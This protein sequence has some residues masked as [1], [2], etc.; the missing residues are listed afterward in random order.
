MSINNITLPDV[1]LANL[2]PDSLVGT[3][4]AVADSKP[5]ATMVQVEQE[6][7]PVLPRENL[8]SLGH[9][10]KQISIVVNSD[11]AVFLPDAS[12]QFLTGILNACKLS[13]ADVAL[14]NLATET[15]INYKEVV[16]AFQP[17][18]VLLFDVE[19]AAFG[20]P[21]TFPHYQL[22]PFSG[23]TFLYSP[24]LPALEN[25]RAEKMKLW[26]SLKRLF[27]I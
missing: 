23:I 4:K 10:Q 12:L 27:N 6:V 15:S 24:S 1:L 22:Q 20:L 17:K 5:A 16:T 14:V 18:I 26:A 19:P 8:K 2:Y 21:M 25:D 13:M 9:N 11:E 7:D 3:V